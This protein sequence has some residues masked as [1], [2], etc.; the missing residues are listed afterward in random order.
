MG[1]HGHLYT[2]IIMNYMY[3][4]IAYLECITMLDTP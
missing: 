4:A 2:C 3:A 1:L